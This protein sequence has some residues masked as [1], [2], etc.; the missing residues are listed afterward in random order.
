MYPLAHAKCGGQARHL[1]PYGAMPSLQ[2]MHLENEL[3]RVCGMSGKRGQNILDQLL[4]GPAIGMC[5][6]AVTRHLKRHKEIAAPAIPTQMVRQHAI[7]AAASMV[8]P[9][10][11]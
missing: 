2:R 11:A 4:R 10:V 3:P 6:L 5:H 9:E 8:A 1:A 7:P